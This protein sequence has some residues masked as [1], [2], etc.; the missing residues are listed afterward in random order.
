[1]GENEIIVLIVSVMGA[2]FGFYLKLK[3]DIITNEKSR[4]QPISDL[5]KSIIELNQTIKHMNED[6]RK[7]ESRVNEH[8][9]QIDELNVHVERL[10]TKMKVYYKEESL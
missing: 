1:M 7:L 8:G 9:K 10:D 3:N 2:L 6:S 5:N 4:N